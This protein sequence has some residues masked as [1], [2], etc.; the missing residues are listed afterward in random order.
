MLCV[1]HGLRVIHNW[2]PL[3][4]VL[5][6]CPYTSCCVTHVN[7]DVR[8]PL[9][10]VEH[11]WVLDRLLLQC[12][13]CVLLDLAPLPRSIACKTV[14]SADTAKVLDQPAIEVCKA[15]KLA[16]IGHVVWRRPLGDAL[17]LH[18]VH[19]DTIVRHQHGDTLSSHFSGLQ[20]RSCFFRTSSVT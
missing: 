13:E 10:V 11:G 2:V 16:Y 1:Q 19:L 18:Q 5:Q 15:K 20:N 6:L 12:V 8:L 17:H 4:V 9:G 7:F 14:W 3:A